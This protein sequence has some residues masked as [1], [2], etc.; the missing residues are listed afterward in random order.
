M[1]A[2]NVRSNV[3]PGATLRNFW[4]TAGHIAELGEEGASL[5]WMGA[6]KSVEDM[7]QCL[8][9]ESEE[10]ALEFLDAA[11]FTAEKLARF[12]GEDMVTERERAQ[13]EETSKMLKAAWEAQDN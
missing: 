10:E 6:L 9:E 3:K 12:A 7:I 4:L 8:K 13:L 2:L 5:S 1:R 11:F